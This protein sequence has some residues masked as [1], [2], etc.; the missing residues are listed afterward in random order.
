MEYKSIHAFLRAEA[1]KMTE[2][3]LGKTSKRKSESKKDQKTP[4]NIDRGN[5]LS[6][7]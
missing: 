2:M 4:E 7:R 6:R 1:Y 5:L 3:N